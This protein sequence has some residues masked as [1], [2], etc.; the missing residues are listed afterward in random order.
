V[1]AR[2]SFQP[3]TLLAQSFQ[4][5]NFSIKDFVVRT[6]RAE[7]RRAQQIDTPQAFVPARGL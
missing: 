6:M 2:K 3:P 7:P 1:D 4:L 5:F